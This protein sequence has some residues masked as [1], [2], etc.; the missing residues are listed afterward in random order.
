M[1]AAFEDQNRTVISEADD[2]LLAARAACIIV[3]LQ[4]RLPAKV[5]A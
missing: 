2:T 1:L 4:H 5:L 3:V